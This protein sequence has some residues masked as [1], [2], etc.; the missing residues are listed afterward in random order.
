MTDDVQALRKE[1]ETFRKN[2]SK[3]IDEQS[4]TIKKLEGKVKEL[5]KEQGKLV[6]YVNNLMKKADT[7]IKNNYASLRRTIVIGNQKVTQLEN[8]IS[9]ISSKI[10]RK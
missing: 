5:E 7:L 6:I 3:E 8:E 1:F 9:Q 10:N 4:K 2:A